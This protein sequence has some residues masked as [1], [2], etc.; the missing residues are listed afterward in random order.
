MI[1]LSSSLFFFVLFRFREHAA[2]LDLHFLSTVDLCGSVVVVFV[3]F[4]EEI[5]RDVLSLGFGDAFVGGLFHDFMGDLLFA[6]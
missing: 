4:G 1:Q 5:L 6:E 3:I 2:L